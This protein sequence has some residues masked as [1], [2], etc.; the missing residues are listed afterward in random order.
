MKATKTAAAQQ[1]PSKLATGIQG[2][3]EMSHGGLTLNR[4]NPGR[5]TTVIWPRI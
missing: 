1:L 3:D 2:F 5:S 4:T